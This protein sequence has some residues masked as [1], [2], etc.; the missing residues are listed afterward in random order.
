MIFSNGDEM[1]VALK[2]CLRMMVFSC[3]LM[4]GDARSAD[5]SSQLIRP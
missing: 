4:H 2:K 3:R 1:R 5:D